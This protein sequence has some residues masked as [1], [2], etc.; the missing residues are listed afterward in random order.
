MKLLLSAP[1]ASLALLLVA[2]T[3]NGLGCSDYGSDGIHCAGGHCYE[4]HE[5]FCS[6]DGPGPG[7][8]DCGDDL[9]EPVLPSSCSGSQGA[10]HACAVAAVEACNAN[11]ACHSFSLDPGWGTTT[12]KLWRNNGTGLVANVAWNT[13]I[14]TNKTAPP[15]PAPA[16]AGDCRADLDCSLNGV[17]DVNGTRKCVCDKPWAGEACETLTFKPVTFPQGYG[18]VPNV[19]SW[20]GGIIFD[21]THHHMFVSRM[22]NDCPLS[23]WGANSRIDHAVSTTGPEGPYEFKDVAVNTWAHNAAPL[24]LSDGTY[25]IVHIGMGTGKC[26]S[27]RACVRA[28]VRTRVRVCACWWRKRRRGN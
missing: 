23:T 2:D 4:C 10:L 14:P 25:A 9:A 26:A 15:S 18:M 13:W 22:T 1:G 5:G 16:P 3:T 6:T 27:V 8:P 17:C 11:S 12:A 20:G 7:A 21:G 19:T 28:C 24:V